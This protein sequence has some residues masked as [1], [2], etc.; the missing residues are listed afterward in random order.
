[1]EY[2]KRYANLFTF[3]F[4]APLSRVP[5]CTTHMQ[6]CTVI[7]FSLSRFVPPSEP[8]LSLPCSRRSLSL[9]LPPLRRFPLWL[10]VSDTAELSSISSFPT[11][12]VSLPSGL[13]HLKGDIWFP[14][15]TLFPYLTSA[16]LL[17][18][19][20]CFLLVH[21]PSTLSFF[22]VFATLLLP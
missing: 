14:Y 9:A 6:V 5:L 17:F 1:M 16:F 19:S 11:E 12:V 13:P 3:I 10:T 22:S 15:L 20:S 2:V 4:V 18:S 7:R 21:F 8:F